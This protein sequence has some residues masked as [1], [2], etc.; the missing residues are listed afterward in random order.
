MSRQFAWLIAGVVALVCSSGCINP[1]NT[2]LPVCAGR[3]PE[4]E[5]R[6]AQIQDPYPDDRLGPSV[7]FRPLGYQ[8][9]RSEPQKAKDQSYVSFLRQ[10]TQQTGVPPQQFGGT[11]IPQ[12]Y[13]AP[14]NPGAQPGQPLMMIP[15]QYPY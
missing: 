6:E 14:I 11:P 3:S 7:G 8:S 15:Q 12:Q 2:R 10:R 4:Y 9:P 1:W 5:R 13:P